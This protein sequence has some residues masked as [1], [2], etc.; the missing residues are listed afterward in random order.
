M[1]CFSSPAQTADGT[2]IVH[3]ALDGTLLLFP[4]SNTWNECQQTLHTCP[5][6]QYNKDTCLNTPHLTDN[7][8][9]TELGYICVCVMLIL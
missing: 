7:W 3:T 5:E 6:L 4:G 9:L 1:M 2:L 8:F